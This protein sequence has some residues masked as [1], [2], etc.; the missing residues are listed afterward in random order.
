MDT[1]TASFPVAEHRAHGDSSLVKLKALTLE[2]DFNKPE[3][4]NFC[5]GRHLPDCSHSAYYFPSRRGAARQL[6]P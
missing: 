5:L 6:R 3:L 4:L 1:Y 2:S